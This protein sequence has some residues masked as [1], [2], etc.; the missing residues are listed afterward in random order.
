MKIKYIL[1]FISCIV[2]YL[3]YLFSDIII[4]NILIDN[5]I[6]RR[7]NFIKS[8]ILKY[9][10][11]LKNKFL[12][13]ILCNSITMTPGTFVLDILWEEKTIYIHVFDSNQNLEKLNKIIYKHFEYYLLEIYKL[14]YST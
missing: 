4:S 9:K 5:F 12:L 6:L 7:N 10:F 1:H 8:T 2:Y 11:N 3:F 13:V 14:C